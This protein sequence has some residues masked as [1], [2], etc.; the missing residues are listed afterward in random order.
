M[1]PFHIKNS[2]WIECLTFAIFVH[3][4][5][6]VLFLTSEAAIYL[7]QTEKQHQ[8]ETS[9]E[10]KNLLLVDLEASEEIPIESFIISR[11]HLKGS[12]RLRKTDDKQPHLPGDLTR[13]STPAPTHNSFTSKPPSTN[14]HQQPHQQ[15]NQNTPTPIQAELSET[16]FDFILNE[17]PQQKQNTSHKP[18]PAPPLGI[19]TENTTHFRF[20]VDENLYR[21][22]N[23]AKNIHAEFFLDI[24]N[25]LSENLQLYA[26][27][28]QGA[29]AIN[30]YYLKTGEVS[31]TMTID[32]S[33][34]MQFSQF[35][36]YS[37]AQPYY[38]YLIERITSYDNA[39]QNLPLEFLNS[40]QPHIYLKISL[41]YKGP[42]L[43]Q[44]WVSLN[45][46]NIDLNTP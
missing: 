8:K 28:F 43:Y 14:P 23:I 31:A 44:W 42:P 37:S 5:L 11:N 41:S 3:V 33:G 38:N 40:D 26:F 6:F 18:P 16:T 12:G 17:T 15:S 25:A 2:T 39:V 36:E 13:N 46:L 24:K 45:V 21:Q 7:A 4:L 9:D 27:N 30:Y 1:N 19:E 20:Y 35:I 10:A 22:P 32:R 29:G 34:N